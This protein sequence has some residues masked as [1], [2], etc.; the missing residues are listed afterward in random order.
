MFEK[1]SAVRTRLL[2]YGRL[3]DE[4]HVIVFAKRSLQL[5]EEQVE[6]NIFLYPTNARTRWGHLCAARKRARS[7]KKNGIGIDVV[8]TQDP[9]EAGLVGYFIARMFRARLHLQVHTDL[10]SPYFLQESALNR[11]RVGIAK[12]LIPRANAIRVVSERIK[13]SLVARAKKEISVIPIFVDAE[14][15]V[16]AQVSQDLK[17]KYPQFNK[18]LL[19]A[20]RLSPEKN[21]SMAI[22]MMREVVKKHPATGLV[23]VGDGAEK[24]NLQKMVKDFGL[25]NNVIF[26]EW[27]DDVTSYYKTADLFL[28]PSNYEGYGMTIVEALCAGCPVVMTDVGC[29]GS[30]VRDRENG[31]IVPVGNQTLFTRAAMSILSDEVKLRVATPTL[32]TK[33][34]YLT[35]YKKSWDD[36]LL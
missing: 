6:P 25:A 30:V 23:I 8:T 28:L 13:T 35:S 18:T 2:E 1:G 24:G 7:L 12:F 34:E 20:S 22:D 4:L 27:C 3:A 33:D 29:A 10:M 32:P 19:V 11:V 26:E 9:F 14:K 21:V 16:H 5:R 17:K 36:A 15:I 31:L